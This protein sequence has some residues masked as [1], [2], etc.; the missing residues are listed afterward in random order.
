MF[1]QCKINYYR[2]Y[3][4]TELYSTTLFSFPVLRSTLMH[5]HIETQLRIKF[6]ETVY[7]DIELQLKVS[8]KI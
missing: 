6:L 8:N 7:N 5:A 4:K 1:L 2:Y 3:C